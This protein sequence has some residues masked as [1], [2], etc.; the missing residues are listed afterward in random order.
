MT[1]AAVPSA[2]LPLPSGARI[3]LVGFGTWELR[4]EQALDATRWALEAGYRHVDTATMYANQVEVGRA[5]R[6]AGVP[7]DEVF[8]TTKLPADRAGEPR[9]VLEE[10]LEQLGVD[11]VDLWLVHWPPPGDDTELWRAFVAAR[12]E[13][14][15][16]DVGVS[17]YS[18]AQVDRLTEVVGT[19]P[20]VNQVP[21]SP[22]RFDRAVLDGHRERGVV[23]EGYSTLRHGNLEHPV[24]TGIAERLGRTP[25]QVLVRWHVQHEVVVIPRSRDRERIAANAD[26]DGFSLS[27]D[28][29][30]AL[31]GITEG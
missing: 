30:V 14:L 6:D 13:G 9:R 24:V 15:V 8:L 16:R 5:L 12:D 26:V 1:T 4:G 3:P 29:M 10:S 27:A 17:N 31:D 2:A 20:A 7:R 21:W 11:V 18:L 28:D 23:L 25:A 19:A 22:K